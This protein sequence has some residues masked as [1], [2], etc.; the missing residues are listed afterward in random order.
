MGTTINQ[1]A[2]I[3]VASPS[4]VVASA[5]KLATMCLS[6]F[7]ARVG[8]PSETGS[9]IE[10]RLRRLCISVV[11]AGTGRLALSR[12]V[13]QAKEALFP[14]WLAKIRPPLLLVSRT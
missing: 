1:R 11:D 9:D 8:P 14:D 12:R 4:L 6:G 7:A 10:I 2:A 13:D 3:A 5:N